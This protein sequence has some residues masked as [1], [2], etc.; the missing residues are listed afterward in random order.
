M[1]FNFENKLAQT[2]YAYNKY[3]TQLDNEV[4]SNAFRSNIVQIDCRKPLLELNTAELE[5]CKT[6]Q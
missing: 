4:H 3:T 2:R 5:L 6:L 1:L